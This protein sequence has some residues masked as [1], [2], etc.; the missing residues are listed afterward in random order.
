MLHIL[1]GSV[2]MRIP[3]ISRSSLGDHDLSKNWV[4]HFR[5]PWFVEKLGCPTSL[6]GSWNGVSSAFEGIFWWNIYTLFRELNLPL[7]YSLG[8]KEMPGICICMVLFLALT[9]V[10]LS[11]SFVARAWYR[12]LCHELCFGT[13]IHSSCLLAG[14]GTQMLVALASWVCLHTQFCQ[15]RNYLSRSSLYVLLCLW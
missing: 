4:V 11:V 6:D 12:F 10:P 9:D 2:G 7:S 8:E 3:L 14:V 15:P 5:R 1:F 13:Y